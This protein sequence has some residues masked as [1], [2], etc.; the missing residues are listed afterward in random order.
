MKCDGCSTP[1]DPA[2]RCEHFGKTLCEDCYMEALSPVKTCDPWAAY[3]AQRFEV[4][5]KETR[6]QLNPLQT[7]IIEIIS[8]EKQ[9]TPEA[10]LDQL[11]KDL[12]RSELQRE[13]ATLKH[14]GRVNA[15]KSGDKILL[16]AG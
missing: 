6:D 10:L 7:R 12:T 3:N 9:I 8:R 5:H 2:D 14:M 11:D 15:K 13:F 4:N 16:S 1:L